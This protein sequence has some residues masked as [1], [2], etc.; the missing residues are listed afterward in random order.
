MS[1]SQILLP[2]RLLGRHVQL[3]I[4]S[5]PPAQRPRTSH[6]RE[7]RGESGAPSGRSKSRDLQGPNKSHILFQRW[8]ANRIP[9]EVF[10]CARGLHILVLGA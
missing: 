6:T 8:A 4:T 9:V 7:R 3:Q 5:L 1:S 2:G 10:V